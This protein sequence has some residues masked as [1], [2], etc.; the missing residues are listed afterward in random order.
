M[1]AR[2]TLEKG[3]NITDAIVA[4][5]PEHKREKLAALMASKRKISPEDKEALLKQWQHEIDYLDSVIPVELGGK[6]AIESQPQAG[7]EAPVG[8]MRRNKTT[9]VVEKKMEDGSWQPIQ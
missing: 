7:G 4:M 1:K 2:A 3:N 9:G 5:A 6:K 8:T